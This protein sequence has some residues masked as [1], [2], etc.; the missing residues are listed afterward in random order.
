MRGGGD[1]DAAAHKHKAAENAS[2]KNKGVRVHPSCVMY[3]CVSVSHL[4]VADSRI[5]HS[6]RPTSALEQ[7]S[8]LMNSL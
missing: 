3:V 4:L 5:H 7:M 8:R 6:L 1:G 2:P